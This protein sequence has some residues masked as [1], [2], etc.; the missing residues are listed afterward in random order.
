[1]WCSD[2]LFLEAVRAFKNQCFIEYCWII[3]SIVAN[4]FIG[5]TM[6]V[7]GVGLLLTIPASGNTPGPLH[8][9]EAHIAFGVGSTYGVKSTP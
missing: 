2:G 3:G 7:L 4:T 1:M 9:L 8:L 6:Q 5:K